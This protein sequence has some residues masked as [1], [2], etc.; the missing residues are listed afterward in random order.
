MKTSEL[1]FKVM[2]FVFTISSRSVT[3]KEVME[4]NMYILRL[5]SFQVN[6]ASIKVTENKGAI[7]QN[8]QD[9]YH[10]SL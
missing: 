6:L 10:T 2:Q 9:V 4:C 1:Y 7:S 3:K 8:C 5:G